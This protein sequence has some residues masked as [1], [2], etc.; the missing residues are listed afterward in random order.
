MHYYGCKEDHEKTGGKHF[1]FLMDIG[2]TKGGQAPNIKGKNAH[3]AWDIN[4]NGKIY[5]PNIAPV[6]N[7]DKAWHYV[8]KCNDRNHPK[9]GPGETFGD[10][11]GQFSSRIG[12]VQQTIYSFALKTLCGLFF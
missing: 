6:R 9:H 7:I 11:K 5:H 8:D 3:K 4:V 1:H 2:M 12:H 10:M